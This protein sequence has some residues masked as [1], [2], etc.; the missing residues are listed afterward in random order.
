MKK[1]S[2]KKDFFPIS[3]TVDCMQSS[4]IPPNTC[5]EGALTYVKR[6]RKHN[7]NTFSSHT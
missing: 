7:T 4:L 6:K 1:I 5:G 3:G 2:Y